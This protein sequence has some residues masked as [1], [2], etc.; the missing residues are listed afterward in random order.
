[1]ANPEKLSRQIIGKPGVLPIVWGSGSRVN[2]T[3][4]AASTTEAALPSGAKVI[5]L[6][7]TEAIWIRFG[8][9]GMN[10][11]AA[12][13]DSILFP[14]GEKVMPVPLTAAGVAY[15]YFRVMR[16]GS[17]DVPVQI[18]LVSVAA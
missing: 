1:M 9:T 2:A 14:A 10:A 4:T 13:T 12:D 8:N 17:A 16:V 5:E 7:A 3:A 15:D 11:A 18:E 6:R